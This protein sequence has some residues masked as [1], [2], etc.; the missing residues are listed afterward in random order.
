MLHKRKR[1]TLVRGKMEVAGGL[2]REEERK[3]KT[4]GKKEEEN[5]RGW[6]VIERIEGNLFLPFFFHHRGCREA[7]KGMEKRLRKKRKE[8]EGRRMIEGGQKVYFGEVRL[9]FLRGRNQSVF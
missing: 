1:K 3:G 4:K 6:R 2:E 9:S 8:K 5:L 7:D